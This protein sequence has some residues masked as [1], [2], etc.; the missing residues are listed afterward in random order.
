[1]K[2]E[3]L[4]DFKERVTKTYTAKK[5]LVISEWVC[6]NTKLRGK[7]FNFGP[8][9]EFQ[10]MICDD[11]HPNLKVKKI[12]Q[13]GLTELQL[14]K[15]LALVTYHPGTFL[16]YAMPNQDMRDRV[17]RTRMRPVVDQLTPELG[18]VKIKTTDLYQINE[19]FIAMLANVEGD[20][21][22]NAA[23]FLI[24]DEQDLSDQEILALYNSR[25]Q[26]SKFKVR[27]DFSTPT[28]TGFGVSAEFEISDQR[29]YMKKCEHCG[30]WQIPDF[31]IKS[32]YI[33]NLPESIYDF[34]RDFDVANVG[35][36]DF[37]NAYIK[38]TDCGKK[39]DLL[40]GREW[41]AQYPSRT[42]VRGY[43]VRVFST[44]ILSIKD[45]ALS[46]AD[47]KRK[48]YLRR[49]I[50]TVLGRPYEDSA[51]R[52]TETEILNVLINPEEPD[53][54]PET[55]IFIGCDMGLT[56]HLVLGA[57]N[58]KGIICPIRFMTCPVEDLNDT[59]EKLFN[60]YNIVFGLI[61]R[62]P[63]TPTVN[64]LRD[65]HEHKIVPAVYSGEK[66]F[67]P[68]NSSQGE[69]DYYNIN[70]TFMA[71]LVANAIRNKEVTYEGFGSYGELLKSHLRDS[72]RELGKD[73]RARWIKLTGNDHFFHALI[74]MNAAYHIESGKKMIDSP[75]QLLQT[76][77]CDLKYFEQKNKWLH[78]IR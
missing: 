7:P 37:E 20:A 27:Q 69:L 44:N 15:S 47:Y 74:Y 53:I 42:N 46:L 72:C 13:V 59:L 48:G 26:A 33:P 41:V 11:T 4:E 34:E 54:N 49:G 5:P 22:S 36:L 76:V 2:N 24:I 66:D 61:D 38:C 70:R 25:L 73:G 56:C 71:D 30:K 40:T 50:N 65:K 77:V 19:S 9:Y 62:Y 55:P 28:F 51:T 21:T 31:D 1:M 45:I 18:E 10:K 43:N 39:M 32:V 63:Y 35:E 64:D 6:E 52:L 17:S 67:A 8:G 78:S 60:E 14:R 23:D 58:S 75:R 3:F 68:V 57:P 29:E 12:S 16:I